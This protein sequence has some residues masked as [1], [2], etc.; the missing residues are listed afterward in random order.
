MGP[1]VH[2]INHDCF[3]GLYDCLSVCQE[4]FPGISWKTHERNG[5]QF[6]MLIYPDYLQNRIDLVVV[7]RFSSFWRHFDLVKQVNL[8]VSR[9][10]TESAWEVWP[11]FWHADVSRPPSELMRFW[12]QSVDFPFLEPLLRSETGQ[13]WGF[14]AFFLR[15]HGRN[16]LNFGMLMYPDHLPNWLDFGCSLLIFLFL[17]PFLCCETG[18]MRGFCTF[19]W[20]RM[21]EMAPILAYWCILIPDHLL[22][23]LNFG[24]ALLIFLILVPLWLC[25][26]GHISGFRAL[27]GEHLRVNVVGGERRHISNALSVL[28]LKLKHGQFFPKFLK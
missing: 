2:P 16:D 18:Q 12:S 10:F 19:S 13:I 11:E 8:G 9:H 25:E 21:G 24:H 15:T 17:A 20:E 3:N 26:T 5:L 6:G 23:L 22:K 27:S 1:L 4:R 14:C 28:L 7:C